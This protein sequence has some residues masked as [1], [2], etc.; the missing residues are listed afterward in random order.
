MS[1]LIRELLKDPACATGQSLRFTFSV[2]PEEQ[3][4]KVVEAGGDGG[5]VRAVA[6]L[7]DR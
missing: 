2:R 6:L 7:I 1:R 3:Y 5:V 4:G